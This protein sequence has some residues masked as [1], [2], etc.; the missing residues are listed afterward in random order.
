MPAAVSSLFA[1][2]CFAVVL[3]A[4]AQAPAPATQAPAPVE[5]ATP[6]QTA[7][8]PGNPAVQA[9]AQGPG[10]GAPSAPTPANTIN[11]NVRLVVL[12]AV[13]VD[14]KG[15]VVTDLRKDEFHITEEKDPQQI[16]N[17]YAPGFFTPKPDQIIDS[18]TALDHLA[19][20]A[21]VNIVVLDEFNTRFEDM[22]FARYSLKKFLEKQP[23]KL[24]TPTMLCAVDLQHFTVVQDYTQDKDA[25]ISALDHHFAAYPWQAHSFSWIAERYATAFAT[26]SRVA[27]ASVGHPGHKNMIWIGRGLPTIN[28]SQFALDDQQRINSAVQRTVNELRD[29]RVTLYTI[30]PAGLMVDPGVYGQAAAFYAP[31]G[32]DPDFEQLARATGGRTLHG[33]NDVDVQIGSAIRDGSDVYSF[34]YRPTDEIADY[35]KFRSI[36][37]TVD[38]PGL[39]VFTR[40]GYYLEAGPAR[41]NQNG[42]VGRKLATELADASNSNM[43]YDAVHFAVTST[44]ADPYT[45]NL[46]ITPDTLVWFFDRNGVKPRWTNVIIIVTTFDKKGK[47]LK[48][49]MMRKQATAPP[50][51]PPTGRLNIAL[52]L[53]YKLAPDPKAVRVRFVVRLEANGRMGSVEAAVG[54]PAS[55]S[56]YSAATTA[57]ASP[58]PPSPAAKPQP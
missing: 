22:A 3:G 55:V 20:Q 58:V 46:R 15:N 5:R 24:D 33:R 29:A 19:P 11:R 2:S 1:A 18:T 14:A 34:S 32:G 41:P 25:L 51:S 35:T 28:R 39:T 36:K 4:S 48:E 30:D 16:R 47:Q 52:D 23:A 12:D 17:F 56:S 45:Y 40:Q 38:R 31:F 53:P 57:N 54:Q 13:V 21:P 26:L 9:G 37:V 6:Q 8:A 43:N 10:G 27:E 42:V 7:P 50:N 44:A 49:D